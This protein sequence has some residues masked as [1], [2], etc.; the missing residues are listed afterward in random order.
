MY[1]PL[2]R[3]KKH[4]GVSSGTLRKWAD[5]G[6]IDSIRTPGGHRLFRLPESKPAEKTEETSASEPGNV[7]VYL[8]L[9]SFPG[10]I[11]CN[12]SVDAW[13]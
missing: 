7:V 10:R 12:M 11:K 5:E 2:A 8:Q 3:I 1:V 4:Y 9:P 13:T 6:K